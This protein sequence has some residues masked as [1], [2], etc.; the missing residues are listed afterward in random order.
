MIKIGESW[1]ERI[2][3][4]F[5]SARGCDF[6]ILELLTFAVKRALSVNIVFAQFMKV[7]RR[8]LCA[9]TDFFSLQDESKEK[10]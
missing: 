10:K 8:G 7:T 9:L 4:T 1:F 5:S 6:R 3:G 2:G